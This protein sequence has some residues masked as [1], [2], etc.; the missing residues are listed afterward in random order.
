MSANALTTICWI[1]VNPLKSCSVGKNW[2]MQFHI[3]L[4]V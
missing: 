2:A 4:P 3:D 1:S